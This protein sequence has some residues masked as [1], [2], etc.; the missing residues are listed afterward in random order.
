[1]IVKNII[2]VEKIKRAS[3]TVTLA[4]IQLFYGI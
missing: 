1:M 4:G 2:G 3:Y